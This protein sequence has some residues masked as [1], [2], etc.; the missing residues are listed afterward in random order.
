MLNS[1]RVLF[2]SAVVCRPAL[3]LMRFA[4]NNLCADGLVA[5]GQS[6]TDLVRLQTIDLSSKAACL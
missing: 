2:S 4:A 5:V 1:I 3:L 6:L